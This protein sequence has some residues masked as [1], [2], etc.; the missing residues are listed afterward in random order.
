M[1][2]NQIA[3]IKKTYYLT[4]IC[5]TSRELSML[6]KYDTSRLFWPDFSDSFLCSTAPLDLFQKQK[7]WGD[8]KSDSSCHLDY[9]LTIALRWTIIQVVIKWGN[10]VLPGMHFCHVLCITIGSCVATGVSQVKMYLGKNNP[11]Q[12]TGLR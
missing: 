5:S 9:S 7:T 4:W 6:D 11:S 10:P 12:R 3:P 1:G 2:Q 8:A